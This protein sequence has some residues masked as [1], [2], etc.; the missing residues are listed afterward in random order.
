MLRVLIVLT[1]S[2]VLLP[3]ALVRAHHD[4]HAGA[5]AS[6]KLGTVSFEK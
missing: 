1:M 4:Q 2:P 6:E 3:P 5:L